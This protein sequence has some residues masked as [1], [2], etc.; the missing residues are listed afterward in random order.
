MLTATSTLAPTVVNAADLW[1]RVTLDC[2]NGDTGHTVKF[3]TSTNGT[4]WTQLG[5]SVV[6]ATANSIFDGTAPLEVGSNTGG[7]AN[8][9]AGRVYRAIV[10]NG[11]AGD[12][13]FDADFTNQAGEYFQESSYAAAYVTVY[14][15]ATWAIGGASGVAPCLFQFEADGTYWYGRH[16]TAGT[17]SRYLLASLPIITLVSA[18]A[19]ASLAAGQAALWFDATNGA[20]ALNIKAKQADGSVKTATFAVTT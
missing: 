15:R 5:T 1:V 4:T 3:Y 16:L 8:N 14:G 6:V 13:V 10:L 19:D 20:A 11:V 2:D 7:T 9:L 17:D 12:T 18:P